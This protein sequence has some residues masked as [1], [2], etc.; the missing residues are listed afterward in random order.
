MDKHIKKRWLEALRSDRYSQCTERLTNGKGFCCL[1]VLCNLH[2]LET[3]NTWSERFRNKN[4]NGIHYLNV[5]GTLPS[6]VVTW[7]KL[8]SDDPI[9]KNRYSIESLS[10]LNDCGMTFKQIA[11]IIDVGL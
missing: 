4:R 1:G 2:A 8:D 10:E 11:D 7:A 5:N 3:G 6:V 9:P